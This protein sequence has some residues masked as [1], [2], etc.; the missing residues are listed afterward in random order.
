MKLKQINLF[1]CKN[2]ITYTSR[3]KL[4]FE[5]ISFK[6]SGGTLLRPI[7]YA[8]EIGRVRE[9]VELLY[10]VTLYKESQ[11]VFKQR[12]KSRAEENHEKIRAVRSVISI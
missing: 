10:E 1:I 5:Q 11:P 12:F 7:V 3:V 6:N 2:N 8:S 4:N 9:A